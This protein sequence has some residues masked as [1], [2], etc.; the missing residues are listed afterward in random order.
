MAEQ[1]DRATGAQRGT[2]P[3]DDGLDLSIEELVLHGFRPGDRY[4]IADAV[5]RE[6]TRLFT[7]Q[8]VPPGLAEGHGRTIRDQ[9]TTDKARSFFRVDAG[10]FVV[11]HDATPDA[12]GMQVA[13]TIHRNLESAARPEQAASQSS[14]RAQGPEGAGG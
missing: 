12:V 6:L 8:G 1:T 11:P 3:I 13:L 14:G 5:E 9:E 2:K 7:E 4:A 10:S